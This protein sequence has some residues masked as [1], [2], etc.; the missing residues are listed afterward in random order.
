V[1]AILWTI[2]IAAGAYQLVALLACLRHLLRRDPTPDFF[3]GVSVLKPVYRLSARVESAL[4]SNRRQAYPNFEVLAG[5]DTPTPAA[6]RK[7][8]VLMELARQAKHPILIVS[9]ADI[10]VPPD[11]LGRVVAP[12]ADGRVGLVTC[13][14]RATGESFAARWEA[15]GIA[16][17]FAPGTLVAPLVGIS[18]FAMG[19]TMVFRA[20]DL[21]R[22]GGF[23]ALAPFIADDYQL[24]KRIAALEL[25]V[26]LSKVVVET[27]LEAR[28]MSDAWRHQ[29]RWA[30]TIR[31][32]RG[33]YA[34][35]PITNASFWAVLL[36]IS[37]QFIPGVALLLLRILVGI[38]AGWI[39]LRSPVARRW[40]W[41]MPA[42][43][44]WGLA[45]WAAGMRGH[46]VIWGDEA[47]TLDGHGRIVGSE[48]NPNP[49]P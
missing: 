6:N 4:E 29:I 1:I 31:L 19:S 11:Y 10:V 24:G 13:L 5:S 36:L 14:Y 3:P 25:K 40:W 23:R 27:H 17:D 44:V 43:D 2:A 8:G 9:D 33:A 18:E 21:E 48:P 42:R 12:L 28:S 46:R 45:V 34:G 47:L 15:L 35:L 22:A 20:A 37:G 39:I 26:W 41:L 30:R 16:T 32:S 49:Q 38:T 7:V